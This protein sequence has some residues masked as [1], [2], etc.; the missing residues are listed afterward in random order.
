MSLYS[1]HRRQ[2]PSKQR[3]AA[4]PWGS[5]TGGGVYNGGSEFLSDFVDALNGVG[6]K[7]NKDQTANA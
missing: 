3:N 7:F 4:H 2:C 6:V 1:K 5:T